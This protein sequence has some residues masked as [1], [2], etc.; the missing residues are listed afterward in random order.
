MQTIEYLAILMLA[1]IF[2]MM[3]SLLIAPPRNYHGPNALAESKKVHELD[4]QKY[5]FVIVRDG[6]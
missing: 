3:M 2:G 1:I 5:Q 4:G 6:Q